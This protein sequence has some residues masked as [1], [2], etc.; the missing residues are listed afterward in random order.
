MKVAKV[1]SRGAARQVHG[2]QAQG[3][4]AWTHCLRGRH[5][6]V[7]RNVGLSEAPRGRQ[8]HG[9]AARAAG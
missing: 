6:P 7:G 9:C 2:C 8:H 5:M 4:A 3:L 1:G